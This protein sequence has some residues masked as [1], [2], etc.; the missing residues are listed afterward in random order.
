MTTAM[1]YIILNIEIN[2][3]SIWKGNELWI[4][5]SG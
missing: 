5:P 4:K 1:K 3:K 2:Q